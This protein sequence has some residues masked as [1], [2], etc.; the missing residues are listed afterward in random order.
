MEDR[1]ILGISVGVR[2]Y[3]SSDGSIDK[4]KSFLAPS[5]DAE[6]IS[7]SFSK[8]SI[9]SDI[10]LLTGNSSKERPTKNNIFARLVEVIEKSKMLNDFVFYFSGHG[11][12][13]GDDI[14]LH[15][16]DFDSR[17]PEVSGIKLNDILKYLHK[18]NGRKLIICDCCRVLYEEFDDTAISNCFKFPPLLIDEQTFLI[19]SCSEGQYSYETFQL[20][21]IGSGVF[22]YYLSNALEYLFTNNSPLTTSLYSIFS[23]AKENCSIYAAEQLNQSQTPTLHGGDANNWILF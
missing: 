4:I 23:Y 21:D 14:L 1:K 20:G 9:Q 17:I 19:T 12:R 10:F 15:P 2:D 3:F 5:F 7:E 22:S 11:S 6:L 16:C 8:I 18:I 13:F